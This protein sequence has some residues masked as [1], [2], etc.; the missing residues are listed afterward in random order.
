MRELTRTQ[1]YQNA[2]TW[3]LSCSNGG[4]LYCAVCAC[5]VEKTTQLFEC[6]PVTSVTPLHNAGRAVCRCCTL[7][8]VTRTAARSRVGARVLGGLQTLRVTSPP[9]ASAPRGAARTFASSRLTTTPL[10][11]SWP[12][13]R[14]G[15]VVVCV[16]TTRTV[17]ILAVTQ[18]IMCVEG[19]WGSCGTDAGCSRGIN[20][21]REGA[22]L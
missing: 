2:V 1:A 17:C 18:A 8:R 9:R 14:Y 3:P 16:T 4:E 5:L 6:R 19:G 12:C 22:I 7:Q 11:T 10:T 21:S 20:G 13:R 15:R